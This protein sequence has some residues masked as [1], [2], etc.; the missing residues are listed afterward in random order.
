MSGKPEVKFSLSILESDCLRDM[1]KRD[2]AQA[3]LDAQDA[4]ANS[5]AEIKD[6]VRIERARDANR[7]IMRAEQLATIFSVGL[8]S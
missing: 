8:G 5:E 3:V 6:P 7:R 4:T 1:I 2:H